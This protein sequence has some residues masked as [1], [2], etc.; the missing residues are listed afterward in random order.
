MSVE[1]VGKIVHLCWYEKVCVCV[2]ELKMC[3]FAAV[4]PGKV[5]G[6]TQIA[7]SL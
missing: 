3:I 1:T 2:W 4:D 5:L 7:D 6:S